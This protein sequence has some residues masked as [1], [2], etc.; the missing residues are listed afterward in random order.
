MLQVL[1]VDMVQTDGADTDANI[2]RARDG[3]RIIA[4]NL[5]TGCVRRAVGARLNGQKTRDELLLL[6]GWDIGGDGGQ[7]LH[8]EKIYDRQ[9][10]VMLLLTF[11]G[12]ENNVRM[13]PFAEFRTG[14]KG[15]N[16]PSWV[17]KW[18]ISA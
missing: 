3:V 4:R 8:V 7:R 5:K 9:S 12:N 6:C 14:A 17:S 13:F 16:D 18:K 2:V 11:D 15:G 1:P 10:M